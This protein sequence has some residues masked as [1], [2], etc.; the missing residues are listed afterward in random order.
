[1]ISDTVIFLKD[2]TYFFLIIVGL[3]SLF[4]GSFLNVVIY[5]LPI[6]LSE[7]WSEECRLYLGLKPQPNLRKLNLF[8]PF[9]HCPQCKH[10]ILPW[11]NIPIFSYLWIKG[12]CKYCQAKI[13]SRYPLVEGLTC[14][15]SI[16]IAYRFGFSLQTVAALIFT[17]LGIC[18][19]FI[20][21]DY[22][23]LPDE[24]T[25]SMLW[26]GLFF[27]IFSIFTN[28]HDAIIGGIAGYLIFYFTQF[29]FWCVTKKTGMGQGDYKLLAAM[30]TFLG[31]QLLPLI[32][33]LSSVSGIICTVSQMIIK[34]HYKSVPLPFGPYLILGGWIALM[35][36]TVLTQLYLSYS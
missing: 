3:L 25:F 21:I 33:L 4:V 34:K 10:S 36:G 29:I 1:M 35:F 20:D 6:M 13:S 24:L 26:L 28:S 30:G 12:K 18:L 22:H 17:W 23:L 11:H 31:W 15:V 8:F 16:Y 2:H 32:I 14:L 9:S 19:T 5:R 7:S 27:S